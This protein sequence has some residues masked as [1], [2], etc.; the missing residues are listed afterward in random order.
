MMAM[1]RMALTTACVLVAASLFA[2]EAAK[3]IQYGTPKR[4]CRVDSTRIAESSGLACSR[5][6]K[7]LFWTHND[8]GDGAYMYAFTTKGKL[9]GAYG[10]PDAK[11]R[12]CE[13]AA[14]FELDGKPYLILADIGDNAKRRSSYRLYIV[15]EPELPEKPKR[16]ARF[17]LHKTIV[18]RFPDGSKDGEGMAVDPTSKAIFVVNRDYQG[19]TGIYQLTWPEK[20][21][22]AQIAKKI[23]RVNIK[24][25]NGMDISPDGLRA[26]INTYSEVHEFTRKADETWAEAFKRKPRQIVMPKRR[27]G[28]SV[29][30]GPDG[31]TL[32]VTS[33]GAYCP[34]WEIPVKNDN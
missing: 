13:D 1:M 10:I 18:F 16:L 3:P 26:V 11:A 12:D 9:V 25:A 19:K 29:A 28:E 30:Y 24:I 27:K 23:A 8:S 33:E 31:K 7:G 5:R 6:T 14:S 21:T 20:K 2:G 32:Y 34:L 22:E 15:E 17:T 4:L